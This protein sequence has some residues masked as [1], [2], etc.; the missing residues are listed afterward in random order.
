LYDSCCPK[1][2]YSINVVPLDGVEGYEY[3]TIDIGDKT[4]V[5][6]AHFFGVGHQEPVV[7]S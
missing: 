3:Y 7:V 5:E 1:V 6:D 2:K 4:F